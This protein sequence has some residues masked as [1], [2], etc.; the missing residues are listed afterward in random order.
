MAILTVNSTLSTGEQVTA[1]KLNNLVAT[2]T[3]AAGAV[4]Q[5]TLQLAGSPITLSVKDGGITTTKLSTGHPN[6]DPSSNLIVA[7]NLTVLA[8]T[9]TEPITPNVLT[10]NGTLAVTGNASCADLAPTGDV[11]VAATKSIK[12]AATIGRT[13]KLNSGTGGNDIQFGF[14]NDGDGLFLR[15]TIDGV[16]EYKI[17]L[18]VV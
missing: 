10:V 7:G 13:V 18:T 16:N 3:F 5:A 15:V 14:Q 12:T 17:A 4:D 2:A 1:S 9:G 8:A 11:T 6:W